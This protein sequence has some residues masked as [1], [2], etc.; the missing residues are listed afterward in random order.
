MPALSI[1][2]VNPATDE[3][4]IVAHGLNTGD[5]FL[6]IFTPDAPGIGTIPG[7]LA[8]VTDYAAIRTG[9]N[10][11]KLATSA[12]N[13]LANVAINIT[14]SGTGTLQLLQGLPFR[15]PRLAAIGGEIFHDDDNSAWKAL[16]AIWNL[17]TG[18][19]QTVWT[20]VRFAVPV[21]RNHGN[22]VKPFALDAGDVVFSTGTGFS[23]VVPTTAPGG[24]VV[25]GSDVWF[26][27][28]PLVTTDRL[29]QVVVWAHDTDSTGTMQIYSFDESGVAAVVASASVRV[30]LG[31]LAP[32]TLA[33]TAPAVAAGKMYMLRVQAGTD[34][35]MS[36]GEI[37]FDAP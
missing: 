6:A 34:I 17:L 33:L 20:G 18:Q 8:P 32:V 36:K 24:K 16:V 37:T 2:A 35:T 9:A 3:L 5:F 29:Q 28:P 11:L 1:S 19:A 30:F 14:D 26:K 12:A 23:R 13:A 21:A 27:L 4:T 7:G 22:I 31:G 15:V 25:A 10:T